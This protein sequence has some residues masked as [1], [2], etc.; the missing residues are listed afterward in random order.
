[1]HLTYAEH[2]ALFFTRVLTTEKYYCTELENAKNVTTIF[3]HCI[4]NTLENRD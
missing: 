3:N 1:M 4:M 2:V